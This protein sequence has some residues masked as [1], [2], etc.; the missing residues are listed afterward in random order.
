MCWYRREG[1]RRASR[2]NARS[3]ATITSV[4]I[5]CWQIRSTRM[6]DTEASRET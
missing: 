2:R 5:S 1:S 4:T 3:S 6:H